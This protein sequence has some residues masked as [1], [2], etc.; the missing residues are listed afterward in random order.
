MIEAVVIAVACAPQA[1]PSLVAAAA[2]VG[3]VPPEPSRGAVATHCGSNPTTTGPPA[4]A[5]ILSPGAA[6]LETTAGHPTRGRARS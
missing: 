4:E 1:L 5:G 6:W 3:D 2:D